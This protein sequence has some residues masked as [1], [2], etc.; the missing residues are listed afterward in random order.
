MPSSD[1][2]FLGA[3]AGASLVWVE[4]PSNPGLDV[5]D[6]AGARR[7]RPR[8][9]A[10]C[11]WSTTRSP[12]RSSSARWSSAGP[13]DRPR[14]P[15]TSPAT[16]TSSS[17]TPPPRDPGRDRRLRD[18][19]ALTGA[20]PGPLET[21]LAHRSL[22]TLGV[23][24][25]RQTATATALAELLRAR[26]DV[27][28]VR[29]PGFGSVVCFELARPA[30]P[31]SASSAAAGLVTE[32]TSFGG[33]HASAERRGRWGTDDV[34]EGFIRFSTGRRGHRGP[35]G[36][37]DAGAATRP[38]DGGGAVGGRTLDSA[39]RHGPPL[40]HP[41][42]LGLRAHLGEVAR[43]VPRLRRVEHDGRGGRAGPRRGPAGGGSGGRR[44][45]AAV[46]PT[47][48]REVSAARVPRM[49]TGIGEFDRVLGGGL[50][51]GSLVLLGGSPGIGK[52]TL[53]NMALGNL[54]AA[55]RSTLYVSGEESAAQIRL[56]A[57]RLTG[58][59]ALDVPVVAETDL[60]AVLATLEAERPD[61]CVIDSVQ[62]L[63]AA[64]AD[65]RARLGR[66]GPRGRD[67]G[68]ARRQ[69][70][71]HR[72]PARRARHEGGR[73][74]GAARPRAPRRLRPAV[75]G[76]ARA[77]LPHAARPEEPLRLDERDRRL[78]DV[79]RRPR[80]GPRRERPLR[81][82]GHRQARQRRARRDGGLAPA[83]RR[84][85]GA[86][87]AVG[88]RAPAARRARG[89]TATA[90]RSCSRSSAA[91]AVSAWGPPTSSSTSSAAS[92]STSRAPTSRWRSPSPARRRASRWAGRKA[93]LRSPAS[94]R[95]GSPA[96]CAR[97]G[98]PTAAAEEAA[99]FGLRDVV[100]PESAPT[101]R[102]ALRSAFAAGKASRAA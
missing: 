64:R 49:L 6:V 40:L 45:A 33:V 79:L 63:H 48:L 28:G 91:T 13:L 76:R 72:R 17:A 77:H 97:S 11:S 44:S 93:A 3:V 94:A 62:T 4:T 35:A 96:S 19:R 57:E 29:Y 39:T 50:V 61:V 15:S 51:P 83:A 53:T 21:W 52:S 25:E 37:R 56:R 78:R 86:R 1:E 70:E 59:G 67:A 8:R 60:E 95:S 7:G 100:A 65:R 82:R 85:A 38:A 24:L 26:D 30:R 2:A 54:Q 73:A 66:P 16:A 20:I 18:W 74:R 98:T 99:K 71:R 46:A 12:R 34:S 10:R 69:D 36:R 90:S 47:T 27:T 43:A 92:A 102:H 89:S 58:P 55:G 14:A 87:V 41:R 81:R 9:R 31:P 80:R 5:L 101:L 75:R 32:A 42:L 68:H 23:R 84:G 88:A 22:A